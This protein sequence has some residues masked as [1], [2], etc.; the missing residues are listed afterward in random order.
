MKK[1]SV[2]DSS[3]LI[4]ISESYKYF[5]VEEYSQIDSVF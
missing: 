3:W 2:S 4:S 5:F 1:F